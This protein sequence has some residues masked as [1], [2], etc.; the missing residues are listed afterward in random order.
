MCQYRKNCYRLDSSHLEKE[1]KNF[2]TR[3]LK[4][5]R[6]NK[7]TFHTYVIGCGWQTSAHWSCKNCNK[8]SYSINLVK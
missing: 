4:C 3:T 7:I 1:H 8:Y 2:T 5:T 6:C